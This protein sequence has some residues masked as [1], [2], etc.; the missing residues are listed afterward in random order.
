MVVLPFKTRGQSEFQAN[1]RRQHLEWKWDLILFSCRRPVRRLTL[2]CV[3]HTWKSGFFNVRFYTICAI[4]S[5]ADSPQDVE[6]TFDWHFF[7]GGGIEKAP[8]PVYIL[9]SSCLIAGYF[10]AIEGCLSDY[11]HLS[12]QCFFCI[13]VLQNGACKMTF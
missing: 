9:S 4:P 5:Q 2:H 6:Y 10:I 7:L 1:Q 13:S 11:F 3:A 12:C 8:L